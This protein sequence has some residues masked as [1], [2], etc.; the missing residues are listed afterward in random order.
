MQL[1]FYHTFKFQF[2]VLPRFTI[3]Y[4]TTLKGVA[5]EWLWFGISYLN[6]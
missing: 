4:G 3:L 6:G 5:I 1:E 2:E